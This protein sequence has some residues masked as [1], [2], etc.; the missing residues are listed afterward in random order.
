MSRYMYMVTYNV[1]SVE[2]TLGHV[3]METQGVGVKLKNKNI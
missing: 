3:V 2:V 1:V